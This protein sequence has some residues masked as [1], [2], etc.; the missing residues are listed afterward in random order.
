VTL[1][2]QIEEILGKR[3][4]VVTP[5]I[6]SKHFGLTPAE[7]RERSDRNTR[8]VD[9]RAVIRGELKPTGLLFFLVTDFRGGFL[10]TLREMLT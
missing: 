1:H 7:F 4:E 5:E 3:I 2:Q 8:V 9:M 10:I 6:V